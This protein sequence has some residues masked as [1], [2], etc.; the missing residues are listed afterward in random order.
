MSH[1]LGNHRLLPA[2]STANKARPNIDRLVR[3][4][5]AA[6][7]A[8]DAAAVAKLEREYAFAVVISLAP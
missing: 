6:K 4:I 2:R 8:G 3:E 1:R 5:A 7:K